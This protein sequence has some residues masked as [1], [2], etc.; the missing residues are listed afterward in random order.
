MTEATFE[1]HKRVIDEWFVNGFNR[2]KAYQSVY[3]CSD[4]T[5][6]AN[7]AKILGN[8]RLQ[9]YKRQKEEESSAELK[10]SHERLLKELENWAYS[11]ITETL[12]LSPEQIKELPI[13]FR[14]LITRY[15]TTT[16]ETDYGPETVTKLWFV[17]KEKAMEMIHKHTGFYEK[18]NNQKK[19]EVNIFEDI[20][21]SQLNDEELKIFKKVLQRNSNKE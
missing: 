19:T 14:R 13:E 4:I 10:T 3:K 12:L 9:A 20:D 5:A 6:D 8:T 2:R 7:F 1:K 17:S 15:E 21:L 11:D 16:R 18:D